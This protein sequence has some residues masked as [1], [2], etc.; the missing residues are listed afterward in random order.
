MKKVLMCLFF[1]MVLTPFLWADTKLLYAIRYEGPARPP[2]EGKQIS[3]QI[4]SLDPDNEE[5]KPVG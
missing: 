4:F 5:I 2:L 3:T 1:L